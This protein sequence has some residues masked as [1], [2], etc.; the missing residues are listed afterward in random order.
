V[1]KFWGYCPYDDIMY[2]RVVVYVPVATTFF[3]YYYTWLSTLGDEETECEK[4]ELVTVV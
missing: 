4:S 2:G 3:A 1:N